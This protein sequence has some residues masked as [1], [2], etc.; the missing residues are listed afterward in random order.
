MGPIHAPPVH[1]RTAGQS[2]WTRTCPKWVDRAESGVL[3]AQLLSRKYP[4]KAATDHTVRAAVA[5]RT[6]ALYAGVENGLARA[7]ITQH[8]LVHAH[9][10]TPTPR[11]HTHMRVSCTTCERCRKRVQACMRLLS[12]NGVAAATHLLPLLRDRWGQRSPPPHQASPWQWMAGEVEWAGPSRPLLPL[13]RDHW[14]QRPP[15]PHQASP[16]QRMAGE[17]GRA[18]P[19]RPLPRRL[20]R[21]CRQLHRRLLHCCH[22]G[23][24]ASPGCTQWRPRGWGRGRGVQVVHPPG[25]RR[26]VW[27]GG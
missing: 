25:A 18:G 17:V 14:D 8:T 27:G 5:A 24:H 6:P 10:H 13:L 11:Q 1:S 19:L 16:W 22:L 12:H 21:R 7:H 20:A 2:W 26:K 3:A 4:D 23:R 15:P 9:V